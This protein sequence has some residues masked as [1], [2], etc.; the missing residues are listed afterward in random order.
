VIVANA[1]SCCVSGSICATV[2]I[3]TCASPYAHIRQETDRG[4]A[5]PADLGREHDSGRALRL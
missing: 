4:V 3:L 2:N 5:P 1:G